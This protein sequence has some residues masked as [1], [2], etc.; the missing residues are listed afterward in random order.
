MRAQL[1]VE[2]LVPDADVRGSDRKRIGDNALLLSMISIRER[3]NVA[4]F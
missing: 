1:K 2:R 3:L 4:I